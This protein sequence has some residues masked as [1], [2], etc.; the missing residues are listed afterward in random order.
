[1]PEK[2]PSLGAAAQ[3][4]TG[5]FPRHTFTIP[6][7]DKVPPDVRYLGCRELPT[8]PREVTLR[9][10]T[11]EEEQGAL[12]SAKAKGVDFVYEAAMRA[13]EAV[14]GKQI[15]WELD[16]KEAFFRGLSSQCRDLVILAFKKIALPAPDASALFLASEKIAP[17]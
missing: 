7:A 6:D 4:L 3:A 9:Q 2:P 8:D 10:L 5:R 12:V 16:A 17:S 15:T 14:D 11:F 13:V 1:M